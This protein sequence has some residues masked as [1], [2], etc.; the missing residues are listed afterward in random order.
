MPEPTPNIF[1]LPELAAT[2]PEHADTLLL[3]RYLVDNPT[4]STRLFRVYGPTPAHLHQ[5][6][7]EHL[8]ILSGRGTFWIGDPSS[9]QDLGPGTLLVFARNTTHA[10]PAI[11]EHPLIVLAIDTPR[12][13]PTDIHFL[14]PAAG[15][16]DTFIRETSAPQ[17]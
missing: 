7:D 13:D 12:R 6:S 8:L 16:P 3:D 5:H 2:F 11:L 14:D 9:A 15:T 4:A 1:H 10:T 17:R